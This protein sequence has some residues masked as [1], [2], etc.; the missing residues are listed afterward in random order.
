MLS[1]GRGLSCRRARSRYAFQKRAGGVP[2]S[3][4]GSLLDRGARLSEAMIGSGGERHA[5]C[6]H[7]ASRA[8]SP[9]A[10]ADYR[11]RGRDVLGE[12]LTAV[13]MPLMAAVLLS[14]AIVGLR[15]SPC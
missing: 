12:K 5:D 9:R 15:V 7:T 13:V 1:S 2:G 3:T 6:C 10:H 4:L 11:G 14:S 8:Q